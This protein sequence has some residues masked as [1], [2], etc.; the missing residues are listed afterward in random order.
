M[1]VHV[2]DQMVR[3]DERAFAPRADELALACVGALMA[4]ELVAA[5]KGLVTAVKWTV[6]WFLACM[7]TIVGLQ[8]G[9]LVVPF[10]ALGI[11]AGKCLFSWGSFLLVAAG[12]LRTTGSCLNFG[13]VRR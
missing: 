5:R 3:A 1:P 4:G 11:V 10:A 7:N 2:L 8:V 6:E 13:L 9:H 12:S